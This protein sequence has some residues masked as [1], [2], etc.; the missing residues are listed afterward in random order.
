[1][2]HSARVGALRFEE[3]EAHIPYGLEAYFVH[4]F[5]HLASAPMRGREV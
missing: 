3:L 1:M 4:N 5:L 2:T